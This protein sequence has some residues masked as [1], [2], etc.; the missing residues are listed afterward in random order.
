MEGLRSTGRAEGRG[1]GPDLQPRFSV[2]AAF[3][4]DLRGAWKEYEV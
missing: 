4:N 1:K 2:E 3:G